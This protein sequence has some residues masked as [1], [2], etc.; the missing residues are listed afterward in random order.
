MDS[1]KAVV[2][3]EGHA[4]HGTLP[5]SEIAFYKGLGHLETS[6]FL[7]SGQPCGDYAALISLSVRL[8]QEETLSSFEVR[9]ISWRSSISKS[10]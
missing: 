2:S 10:R 3:V 6:S 4:P 5:I 9:A 8:Q 7:S 1:Q